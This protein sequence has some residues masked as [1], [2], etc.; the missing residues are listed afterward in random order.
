[1]VQDTMFRLT[2]RLQASFAMATSCYMSIRL[3][4]MSI[5]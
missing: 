3:M 2:C 5:S 1:M 4:M